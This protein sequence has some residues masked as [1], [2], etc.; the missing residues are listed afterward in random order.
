MNTRIWHIIWLNYVSIIYNL[1]VTSG[2]IHSVYLTYKPIS[3]DFYIDDNELEIHEM[4]C[5]L[6]RYV[7]SLQQWTKQRQNTTRAATLVG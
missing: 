6:P 3:R 5:F 1:T 2:I 4:C 7:A